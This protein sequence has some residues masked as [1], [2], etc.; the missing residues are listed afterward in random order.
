LNKK[1]SIVILNYNG[2]KFLQQFLPSIIKFSADAEIVVADNASTDASVEIV[3]SMFPQVRVLTLDKN[4][5]FCGGYNR[6]LLQVQSQYYLLLNSD[7]EVTEGWLTP[8]VSL[9]DTDP[10]IAAAQPK[11]KSFSDREMFEYAG[12]AGGFID[13]LGYPFCRGRLFESLEKDT[14]Q[15]DDE[16]EVFWASGACFI[17]RS[18]AFHRM[19][20]FDEDFFAH[21]E[22][23]D[24][25]WRL[26]RDN[27][28]V[29]YTSKS[30][31]YHVG[32]GTLSKLNPRKT[33]LNFRNGLYL[34]VK[35]LPVSELVWKLPIRLLLDYAAA[36]LFMVQGKGKHAVEVVR[37]HLFLVKE[38]LKLTHKRKAIKSLFTGSL[39][40]QF[41]GLIA[42]RYYVKKEKSIR[43]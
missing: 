37:A 28:K 43:V 38:Y 22:E 9:L 36:I 24:L 40:G 13:S 10:S 18:E 41:N 21:M 4:Y 25:C 7:V 16:R 20:G 3:K 19:G 33:F 8:L 42:W 17:I 1:V 12:A 39:S 29:F 14:G 26:K 2:E 23:I 30:T 6:A 31:V 34:L 32:G 15:Y 11:I 27:Q 35:N 5:G